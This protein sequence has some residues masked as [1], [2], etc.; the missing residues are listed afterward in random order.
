MSN[1]KLSTRLYRQA[2]VARKAAAHL[3]TDPR[4]KAEALARYQELLERANY[5]HDRGE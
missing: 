1:T 3:A 4:A 2:N 5:A